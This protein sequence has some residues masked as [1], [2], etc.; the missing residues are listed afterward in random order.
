[1]CPPRI[2]PAAIVAVS[3]LLPAAASAMPIDN[4]P[5]PSVRHAAPPPTRTV[6][7]TTDDTL[8]IAVAGAALLVAMASA[9]YSAV[10]LAP[11]RSRA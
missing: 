4:R 6:I 7:E 11:L 3:L 8:P 9:G 2:L 10:R 1:M 5:P